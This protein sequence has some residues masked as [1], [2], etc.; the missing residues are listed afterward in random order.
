MEMRYDFG[1]HKSRYQSRASSCDVVGKSRC[2]VERGGCGLCVGR[3][4][5]EEWITF[6]RHVGGE[7]G[8]CRGHRVYDGRKAGSQ[9]CSRHG[10]PKPYRE[11][12]DPLRLL[13]ALAAK[14]QTGSYG[15]SPCVTPRYWLRV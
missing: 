13:P 4:T 8:L 14:H 9:F 10:W 15:H 6:P 3:K 1:S 2:R 5:V 12:D 7:W 11:P